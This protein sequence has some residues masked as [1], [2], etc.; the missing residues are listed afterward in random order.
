ME[1]K[2]IPPRDENL[3]Y[4]KLLSV[5]DEATSIST[6]F[7]EARRPDLATSVVLP[8]EDASAKKFEHPQQAVK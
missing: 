8:M 7:F 6:V 2:K 5:V 3:Q 1:S 4:R